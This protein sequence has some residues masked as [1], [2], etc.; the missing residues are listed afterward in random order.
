[1]R[2]QFVRRNDIQY[3]AEEIKR[4]CNVFSVK[5]L[6]ARAILRL[7][8]ST[9]DEIEAF[10][11]P[12][13]AEDLLDPLL[14]PDM[15][16]ACERIFMADAAHNAERVCV[17][18]DYDADGVCATALLTECLLSLDIDCEWYVPDR[19]TEGYG[20]SSDAVKKLKERGVSLIITVDNG[21]SSYEAAD[22]CKELGIDL[23]VTDHHLCGE[24][25]PDAYAVVSAKRPD[26]DYPNPDLCGCGIAFKLACALT[27]DEFTEKWLGLTAVATVAD[28]VP[29]VGENRTIVFTGFGVLQDIDG[30]RAL[31]TCANAAD[32]PITAETVGF[33]IAPRLN[34]AG[35]MGDAGR[36]VELLLSGYGPDIRALAE[37]LENE[38]RSRREKEAQILNEA[39]AVCGSNEDNAPKTIVLFGVSWHI[40]VLGNAASKLVERYHCPVLLFGERD[41][42]YVGSCRSVPG[43]H[44]FNALT[45]Y[46]DRFI[47]YGGH[48]QAAGVTISA[49]EFSSFQKEFPEYIASH[50]PEQCF[51]PTQE[52]DDEISFAE[53]TEDTVR[54]LKKLEPFGNGNPSP[55][56]L[57]KNAEVSALRRIGK[58]GEHLSADLY[59][60]GKNIRSVWFSP[61]AAGKYLVSGVKRSML[62]VP[63]LNDYHGV[64]SAELNVVAV[65]IEDNELFSAVFEKILYHSEAECDILFR[66]FFDRNGYIPLTKDDLSRPNMGKR[67]SL[68]KIRAAN[69]MKAQ[70]VAAFS[71]PKDIFALTVFTELGFF[72]FNPAKECVSVVERPKNNEL[73]NS[74]IYR[75]AQTYCE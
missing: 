75:I 14:L 23:I 30:I 51:I 39:L 19:H 26:S 34:A 3:S 5:P 31:M 27:G 16:R 38:N 28:I 62:V 70:E 6:T 67:Y 40:G 42:D 45:A 41:G 37:E 61:G 64:T 58:S 35:R 49:E 74:V 73:V 15:E 2:Q 36:A 8:F 7:G 66:K 20:I 59:G 11:R 13:L 63:K 9:D 43:V 24:I 72:A 71:D 1:M 17:F 25:L 55:V 65:S 33:L 44:L 60:E 18:G 21:I 68:L 46:K 69:G 4:I 57:L 52:Y 50:Y 48:A 56:F 10:L 29:L 32:T 54:D 53:I 12:D 22:T 47:R